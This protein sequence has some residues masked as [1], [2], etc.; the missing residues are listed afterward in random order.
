MNQSER[1]VLTVTVDKVGQVKVQ[2]PHR[3]VDVIR[4]DTQ[5]RMQTIR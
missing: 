5:T 4:V 3:H 1:Q 2:F